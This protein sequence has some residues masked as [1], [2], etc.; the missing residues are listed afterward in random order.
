MTVETIPMNRR[1]FLGGAM[2]GGAALGAASALS[3]VPAAAHA[4]APLAGS[5]MAGALRRK[6]GDFE[7]TA[8]LDGYLQLGPELIVG[9]EEE[10]A[11]KL[12]E[13][14][15]IESQALTGPVN[16]Y[17]VNTGEKL[18]LSDAGTS[19]KMGPTL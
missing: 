13:A 17:L 1:G 12:R 3:L 16:A 18:V 10:T 2:T 6:V 11:A 19:V 5:P 14:D 4:A 15:F 8:L 9:Y 7:V